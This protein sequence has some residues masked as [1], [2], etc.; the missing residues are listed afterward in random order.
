MESKEIELGRGV[1]QGCCLS[2]ILFNIYLEE[3]IR[4]IELNMK[5]VKIGGRKVSCVRFADDM[6]IL[7]ED[8][9]DL[10]TS[11][12]KLEEACKTYGMKIN[13]KK[14]KVMNVGS[15]KD[16]VIRVGGVRMEQV[17]SFKYLGSFLTEDWRCEKEVRA[18]I[19]IAKEAFTRMK[20]ILCGPLSL[21]LRKR[22]AKCFV[23]SV[24]LYGAETWTLREYEKKK[25]EAFE[26]WIWRRMLKISWKDK[27]NNEKVL[28]RIGERRNL[29]EKIRTRKRNWIGH[30]LRGNNLLKDIPESP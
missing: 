12:K 2:P 9:E 19:G 24:L 18:R 5:G 15:E 13:A 16:M 1:R 17:N 10:E 6:A 20:R 27:L 8:Q 11:V 21:E 30:V 29:M 14:T 22:L 4:E 3:M 25:L 26:M 23:W 28:E 7:A